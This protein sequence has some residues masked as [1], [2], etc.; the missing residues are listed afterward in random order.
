MSCPDCRRK[1]VDDIDGYRCENCNKTHHQALPTYIMTAK[2]QDA[3]GDM[4]VNFSRE[5]GD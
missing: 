5:L 1:V 4:Y 2:V 3:T